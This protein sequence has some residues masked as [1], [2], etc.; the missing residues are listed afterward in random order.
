MDAGGEVAQVAQ[1][2]LEL[3]ERR[4]DELERRS[5]ERR[6]RVAREPEPQ[7]G[8][9][10]L[11][12]G[13]VVEVALEPAPLGVAGLDEPRAGAA[14]CARASALASAAVTSSA[15]PGDALL[16]VGRERVGRRRDV[17]DPRPRSG[18]RR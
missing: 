10:E 12:L 18:R 16:G 7:R 14:S 1:A 17:H 2:G 11:L 9:H 3:L 15:K 5:P 8:A 13:A 6:E 4:V